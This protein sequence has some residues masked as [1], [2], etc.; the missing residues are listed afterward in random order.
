MIRQKHDQFSKQFLG[1]LLEPDGQVYLNYEIQGVSRYADVY[2][3]PT[4]VHQ[5]LGLLTQMTTKACLLEPF[6]KQPSKVEIRQC[7]LK[8]FALHGE[9]IRQA[10]KRIPKESLP[11]N[12]LPRLWIITTSASDNLL[13]FFDA[14][15]SQWGDGVYF[16]NQGLRS[17]IVVVDRLPTTPETLWL[18]ILGKG[19]TQQQAIDEMMAFP[20]KNALR[21]NV[22]ELLSIWHINIKTQ[23]RLTTDDKELLMNLSP[24]YLQWREETLQQGVKE[25]VKQAQRVFV[26][27]WLK[28]RFGKIDEVLSPVVEPLVQLP[29]EESARLLPRLSREELLA[30]FGKKS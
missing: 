26:K 29:M 30:K 16:F 14:R 24:A 12:A 11:E 28:S 19:N 21:S 1:D 3:K 6:R 20:K 5:N 4:T 13:N 9:L 23:N 22:L 10:N 8:L 15:L 7:M 2:F 25:G 17:A 27:S 18:R